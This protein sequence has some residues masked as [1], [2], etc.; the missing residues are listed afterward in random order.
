M[1]IF[2]SLTVVFIKTAPAACHRVEFPTTDRCVD[3]LFSTEWRTL[4]V[5]SMKTSTSSNGN[6]ITSFGILDVDSSTFYKGCQR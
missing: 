4:S 2:Q 3:P 1:G 6:V 5:L